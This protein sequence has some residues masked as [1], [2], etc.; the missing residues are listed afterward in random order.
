LVN[1]I[2][3][4]KCIGQ[5]S[6]PLFKYG[7]ISIPYTPEEKNIYCYILIEYFR[8]FFYHF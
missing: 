5:S 1:V 3:D 4:E 2:F 8:I 7:L 6:R